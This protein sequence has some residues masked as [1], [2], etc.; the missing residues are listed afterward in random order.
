MLV[1]V[2]RRECIDED[3]KIP[4]NAPFEKNTTQM[5]YSTVKSEGEK[6]CAYTE[7]GGGSLGPG[8]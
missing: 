2:C 3:R 7:G 5:W 1:P 8:K 4:V 6:A